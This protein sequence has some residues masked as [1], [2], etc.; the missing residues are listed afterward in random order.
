MIKLTDDMHQF[1]DNPPGHLNPC[2]I[3]TADL[4]GI[5]NAGFIGTVF[6]HK[7]GHVVLPRQKR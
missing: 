4:S 6:C 5:P 3:A 2:I 7:R 1:L